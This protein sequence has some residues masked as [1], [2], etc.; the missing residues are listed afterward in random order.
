MT[1]KDEILEHSLQRDI[2]AQKSKKYFADKTIPLADRWSVFCASEH[3][4]EIELYG[5]GE[6]GAANISDCIYSDFYYERRETVS[7]YALSERLLEGYDE[8]K[9]SN[10]K[11]NTYFRWHKK[12]ELYTV[13]QELVLAKGFSGFTYDW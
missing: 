8:Y 12:P 9:D 10:T 5:D 13:W 4:L 1:L 2:L 7:Y 6:L 3:L 11:E